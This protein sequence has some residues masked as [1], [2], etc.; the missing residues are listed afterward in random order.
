MES[1]GLV[2]PLVLRFRTDRPVYPLKL[3][4]A[5]GADTEVVLY[6]LARSRLTCEGL[7]ETT[8][9]A[10]SS[11]RG[12]LYQ[13]EPAVEPETFPWPKSTGERWLHRF[14]GRLT[15]EAMEQ[16]LVLVVDEDAEEVRPVVY[17]W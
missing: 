15:A 3:T 13:V 8:F 11:L 4:G 14:A 10:R 1:G 12:L 7:L 9:A 17:R 6:V 2:A 16:D 5:A